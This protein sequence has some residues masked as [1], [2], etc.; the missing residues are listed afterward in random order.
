[1]GINVRRGV[2]KPFYV[3][4]LAIIHTFHFINLAKCYFDI[5]TTKKK[6]VKLLQ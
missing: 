6:A 2:S 3:I 1:M 4:L 5:N